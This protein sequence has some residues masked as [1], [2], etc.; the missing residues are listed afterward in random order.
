VD[1]E[2]WSKYQR[3]FIHVL[4]LGIRHEEPEDGGGNKGHR[5]KPGEPA[6]GR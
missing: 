4:Q 1:Y 6:S 5:I 2:L 3:N